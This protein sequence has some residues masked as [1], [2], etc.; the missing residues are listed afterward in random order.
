MTLGE[1]L[2][3]VREQRGLALAEL[4][5]ASGVDRVSLWG[6]EKGRAVPSLINAMRLAES[7][8]NCA[9]SIQGQR[10]RCSSG[11]FI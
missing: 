10:I 1:R 7:L 5:E 3:R 8:G 4:A 11:W 9:V 6:Y 2:R